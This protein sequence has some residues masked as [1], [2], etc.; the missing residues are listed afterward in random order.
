[1]EWLQSFVTNYL[2][3]FHPLTPAGK[4]FQKIGWNS[5]LVNHFH[6]NFLLIWIGIIFFALLLRR[7]HWLN[8]SFSEMDIPEKYLKIF[9]LSCFLWCT[10]FVYY[11]FFHQLGGVPHIP[12]NIACFTQAKLN[13]HG[14]FFGL[15][16]PREWE[17]TLVRGFMLKANKKLICIYP[18]G[19]PLF[20]T[21][22]AFFN[23]LGLSLFFILALNF[24]A[25]GRLQKL[26]NFSEGESFL[27]WLLL[28]SSPAF[29]FLSAFPYSQALALFLTNM[30]LYFALSKQSFIAGI[31]STL[32]FTVRPLDGVVAAIFILYTCRSNLKSLIYSSILLSSG[33]VMLWFYN[34]K[35][36]GIPGVSTYSLYSP[37]I[38]PGFSALVGMKIPFGHNLFSAFN[39]F[40]LNMA[41]MNEDLL[42]W[43]FLSIL[44]LLILLFLSLKNPGVSESNIIK[45][46]FLFTGIFCLAYACYFNHGVSVGAR[47]YHPLLGIF[48]I[49][50]VICSRHF[51]QFRLFLI[52]P[53]L[54]SSFSFS[55]IER[56][57]TLKDY[58]Y[59][60][61][62]PLGNSKI[63]VE[64]NIYVIF[65]NELGHRFLF[66]S[67]Y[68]LN[69]PW[70][71]RLDFVTNKTFSKIKARE[72]RKV[73]GMEF[74]NFQK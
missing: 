25:F 49:L 11:V 70:T 20:L 41:V 63:D 13:A 71:G 64:K 37:Y 66:D 45:P 72:S 47:F 60:L 9:I 61:S 65:D 59:V 36:T 35:I 28:T 8:S 1:M 30:V 27:F 5:Y 3:F 29:L 16:L 50:T 34:L 15:P 74:S 40:F 33:P 51:K 23:C 17:D 42:G 39:N 12:D 7:V 73:I 6:E 10:C 54:I 44:P 53:L 57:T 2:N 4:E 52:I 22:F 58:E 67:F 19:Y 21:P 48:L 26:F 31:F 38:K 14:F 18:F 68:Y 55:I 56:A 32:L 69:K 46:L 43:P 24:F 62:Y